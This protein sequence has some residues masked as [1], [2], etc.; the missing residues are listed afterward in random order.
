M[1]CGENV[2]SCFSIVVVAVIRLFGSG[3]ILNIFKELVNIAQLTNKHLTFLS[4]LGERE[5]RAVRSQVVYLKLSSSLKKSKKKKIMLLAEWYNL[6][7]GI[8]SLSLTVV[9]THYGQHWKKKLPLPLRSLRPRIRH[10]NAGLQMFW[11]MRPFLANPPK[12]WQ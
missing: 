8:T 3:I 5:G 6:R 7:S 10:R 12:E 11:I 1:S 9:S 2:I 4:G